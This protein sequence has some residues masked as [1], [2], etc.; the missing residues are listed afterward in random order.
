[1]DVEEESKK[2]KE[3]LADINDKNRDQDEKAA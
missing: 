3:Q 1:M 2:K